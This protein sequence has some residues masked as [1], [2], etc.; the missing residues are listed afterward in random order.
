M[1]PAGKRNHL[2]QISKIELLAVSD[3]SIQ[4]DYHAFGIVQLSQVVFFLINFENDKYEI[5][6]T[7]K[8]TFKVQFILHVIVNLYDRLVEKLPF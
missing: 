6:I 7:E 1:G 4:A 3:S 2:S 8:K 5:E